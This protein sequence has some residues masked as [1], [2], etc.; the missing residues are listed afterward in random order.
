MSER[1]RVRSASPYEVRYGFC[2]ARRIGDRIL[3]AGTAPILEDGISTPT[4]AY[5]QMLR[6]GTIIL[7]AVA[8]L[9]GGTNDVV[10]TRMFIVDPGDADEVGRAHGEIFDEPVATMVVVAQL[11]DP[12]WRVEAEAEAVSG[13][14]A[15]RS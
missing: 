14:G 12:S 15:E 11:L 13:Q 10:R 4:T 6:C 3:V 2:R 9:G 8:S 1:D 7:E 5:E